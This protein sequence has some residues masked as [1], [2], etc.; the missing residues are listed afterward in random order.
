MG[1]EERRSRT[2]TDADVEA[3]AEALRTRMV[4][5]FYNDLGRGLW[6]LIWKSVVLTVVGVAGYFA[7][8]RGVHT[9]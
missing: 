6:G 3:I 8:A 5:E 1:D 2:L 9:P 4:Q 7:L